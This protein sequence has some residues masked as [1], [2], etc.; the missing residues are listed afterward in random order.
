MSPDLMRTLDQTIGPPV[1]LLLTVI[2][3]II[4][5]LSPSHRGPVTDVRRILFVKPAEMG[6]TV[7]TYSALLRARQLWPDCEI[8]FLVFTEN[9]SAVDLLGLVPRE[10]VF[11]LRT[12][13]LWNFLSDSYH[14]LR[15]IRAMRFDVAIDMEFYSRGAAVL[16][17]FAGA[18][19]SA[20]FDRFT[21]EGLYKGNLLTHPVQY[22]AHIHTAASFA[23][24][25]ES[26]SVPALEVPYLKKKVIS[27]A[28]L[29]LPRF[30]PVQS[31][32]EEIQSL[33]RKRNPRV[34]AGSRL[35]ILNVNAS[36]IMPLRKWPLQNYAELARRFL[37]H[38]D[39]FIV[40]TG[41]AAE[42]AL[43]D[44]FEKDLGT[45]SC[46]NL[47]G[48]TS[49]QSLLT[50]YSQASLMVTNDSGPSHFAGLTDMPTLTLFGPETPEI[51]GP[52]GANKRSLTAGLACSPCVS[53][54]NHRRSP[55]SD[56]ACM[57]A[58]S[59]DEVYEACC[60]LMNKAAKDAGTNP[61]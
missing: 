23:C 10:H 45:D 57:R 2:R 46:V 40:L 61:S 5:C 49:I 15:R 16:T 6:S 29:K 33:I 31:E 44:A 24:L 3:W 42:A 43:A 17:Y 32:K 47:V 38:P 1:C 59:V 4:D 55:C 34:Q 56:A 27:R 28:D 14:E 41:I 25:V 52:L 20:G 54:Y 9:C 39:T 22:N 58:L 50:L 7:L 30:T 35:I 60:D 26:L 8:Y 12:D 36:D 21:M 37:K 13:S 11:K 51:Y 18:R 48:K 53:S 19:A